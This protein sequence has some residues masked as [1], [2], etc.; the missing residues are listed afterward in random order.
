MP[1]SPMA[2]SL[3]CGALL[4]DT[5]GAAGEV[6]QF[7][8]SGQANNRV[9]LTLATG[10]FTV[11]SGA[12][13]TATVFSPAAAMVVTFNAND[14][15]QV[16]LPATGTYVIQVRASNFVSTGSYSLG[17][18]CLLPTSPV[19]ATLFCGVLLSDRR[20]NAAAQVDQFT[21][22]GQA[23]QQ[24]TLT[25]ATGGF[26]VGSGATAT[27]T[28]FSPAAAVVVT[29]NANGQQQLTLADSG[30]YAIQVRASNLVEAAQKFRRPN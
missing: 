13:A 20:V 9:T 24:V 19:D 11:G 2:Q 18:E 12:T 27:A 10:G 17:L 30:T 5:I 1:N 29:F 28:V 26:T 7:T 23:N 15:Q 21:F 14:Q 3:A 4:S 6:D 22:S 8:F 25:L 16:T